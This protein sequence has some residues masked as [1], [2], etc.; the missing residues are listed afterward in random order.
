MMLKDDTLH[1]YVYCASDACRVCADRG[2]VMLKLLC[3]RQSQGFL[4]VMFIISLKRE[5]GD[6]I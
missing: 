4:Y 3:I 6:G 5:V 2:V 1:L